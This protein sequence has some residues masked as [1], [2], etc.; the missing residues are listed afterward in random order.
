MTS[1]SRPDSTARTVSHL[2]VGLAATTILSRKAGLL[3]GVLGG[4]LTAVAHEAFDAP[5][6]GVLADAGL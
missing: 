3:G 5:L 2:L 6:A 4:A 1:R